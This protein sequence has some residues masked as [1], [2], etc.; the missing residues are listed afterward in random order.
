MKP[1]FR[2][3][4]SSGRR[5][6]PGAGGTVANNL[7]ALGVGRI[8]VLGVIGDD[9]FG[10]R[11]GAGAGAAAAIGSDM[12]VRAP[13]MQTFTYTKLINLDTGIEDLGRASI[14]SPPR[15]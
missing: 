12:L 8:A 6:R 13:G 9:G 11:T 14:S 2:A 4:A 15:R 7:A 10:Y 1:E 3:S 5:S